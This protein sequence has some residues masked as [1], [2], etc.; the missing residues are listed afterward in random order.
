MDEEIRLSPSQACKYGIGMNLYY[1]FRIGMMR[2]SI[3][4]IEQKRSKYKLLYNI[5]IRHY[6]PFGPDRLKEIDKYYECW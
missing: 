6:I 4:V 2:G 3:N 5:E 1:G